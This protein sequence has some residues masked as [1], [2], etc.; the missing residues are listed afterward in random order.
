MVKKQ[1]DISFKKQF[2]CLFNMS[3]KGHTLVNWKGGAAIIGQYYDFNL[4]LT[5]ISFW[6]KRK[7]V[8]CSFLCFIKKLYVQWFFYTRGSMD[9]CIKKETSSA[10]NFTKNTFLFFIERCRKGDGQILTNNISSF[11]LFW[12]KKTCSNTYLKE[13]QYTAQ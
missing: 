9:K 1:R 13:K 6:L 5:L 4:I 12:K 3:K 2:K 11:S 10:V 7:H 8:F